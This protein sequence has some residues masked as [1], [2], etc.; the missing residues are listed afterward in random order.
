[1]EG[2]SKSWVKLNI[3]GRWGEN[4]ETHIQARCDGTLVLEELHRKDFAHL[5]DATVVAMYK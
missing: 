4:Q 3:H 5:L 1:M 2:D